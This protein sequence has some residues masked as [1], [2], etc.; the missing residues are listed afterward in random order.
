LSWYIES[1]V[2]QLVA[3]VA[4][5]VKPDGRGAYRHWPP[6]K[7]FDPFWRGD[8]QNETATLRLPTP[9][10]TTSGMRIGHRS[11]TA[12]TD[13]ARATRFVRCGYCPSDDCTRRRPP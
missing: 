3:G 9:S 4:S 8:D 10:V 7:V 12:V 2:F 5:F 6:R 11:G 1:K 13:S